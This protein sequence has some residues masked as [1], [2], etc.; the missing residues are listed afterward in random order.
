MSASLVGRHAAAVSLLF[1]LAVP[2]LAQGKQV[3]ENPTEGYRLSV[4]KAIKAVPTEPNERQVLAKW[5]EKIEFKDK[6]FRGEFDCTV[7]L[8]RIRKAKGPTTG[9][10]SAGGEDE[11]EADGK[12]I[13][14]KTIEELN[15]GATVEE[16]LKKRSIKSDLRVV[17]D[18]K[19]L[20]SRDGAEFGCKQYI[21]ALPDMRVY[22]YKDVPIIRSYLLEDETEYFGLVAIGPFVDPWRDIV[23]DMCK[24]LQ[25][26]QLGAGDG[27]DSGAQFT[28]AD[29]RDQVR[30]KLVKGWDAYDTDHFI[31]VTNTK[32]KKVIGQILTDLELM[33]TSYI[34][35]F[36]PVE[37][38]DLEKV[39]SAVRFCKTY[40]DYKAYGGPPGSGGYWNFVDEELVLVDMQTLD[41]RA[42]KENPNLKN[43]QVL[44][45]L[46]HEAMHQYFYYANG[47][48]APASWYNEG[49][50]EVFGG[51]VPD[52]RKNEIAR[53]DKNRFRMAWIKQCQRL[54]RWP[55]LR[56]FLKMTQRE[57]YGGSILQNYAFGWAF[58]FFLEEHRLDPKGNREWGAIPDLYLKSL[59]DATRQKR[60]EL[61]ID[62][63][64][65]QWL[66][67][68]QDEIQEMAFKATFKEIDLGALEKAWVAA[69]KRWR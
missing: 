39:I 47:N 15:S 43:I 23:E 6:L 31:F 17:D 64:D 4:S 51:S 29:F 27:T 18:E 22:E 44:D 8:V 13:R 20:K 24:S 65:K 3:F 40:D 33:R 58:C 9:E 45:I 36:P 11:K 5:G 46:Y 67:S 26:I 59:R 14:A 41:P 61:K 16:F 2:A 52:R 69:M 63:K 48:L 10:P 42:Y 32:D 35:R 49:F 56:A 66:V 7:M 21:G 38:V 25:R 60:E 55:D 34:R 68:Y 30:R 19:K 28:N 54:D 62:E 57:F 1:C 50:G 37:G 53:V 12:T